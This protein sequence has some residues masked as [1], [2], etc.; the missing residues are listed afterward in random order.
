MQARPCK[1]KVIL[2]Y[3]ISPGKFDIETVSKIKESFDVEY[4]GWLKDLR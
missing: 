3:I 1:S 2:N 4:Y